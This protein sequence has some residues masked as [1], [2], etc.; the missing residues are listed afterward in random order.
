M[1]PHCAHRRRWT[2]Q[3]PAAS[4]STQPVP[5]GGT[6]GSIPGISVIKLSSA[7]SCA[8][9]GSRTRNRVSPGTDTNDR[10]PWCLFTTIR[11]EISS[12][13]PVPSPTGLVVKNGSNIR[14]RISGGTP[15]PVSPNSTNTWS[16]SIPVRTVSVPE[17]FIADTALSIRFVH[18]WFSSPA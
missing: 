16:R 14:S 17:P 5:L 11:Q 8:V 3:P 12:P 4:H 9:I 6:E 10:S 7:S 18:T 2:H 1:C 15:G 13:S